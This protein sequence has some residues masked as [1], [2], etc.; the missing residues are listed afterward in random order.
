MAVAGRG[1][2][3]ELKVPSDDADHEYISTD[4][5]WSWMYGR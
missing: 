5:M 1:A 3:A 4:I 2:G